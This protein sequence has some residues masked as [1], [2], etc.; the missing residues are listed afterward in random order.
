[1]P[2]PTSVSSNTPPPAIVRRVEAQSPYSLTRDDIQSMYMTQMQAFWT[3][4]VKPTE[5][6]D[7]IPLDFKRQSGISMDIGC[8]SRPRNPT[9]AK[10]LVGVDV[11]Q[12][13]DFPSEADF[14]LTKPGMPLPMGDQSVDI[15]TAF[16]FLEHCWWELQ[17]HEIMEL[18]NHLCAT[19]NLG[20][21]DALEAIVTRRNE[22]RST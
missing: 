11:V 19:P 12:P 8:G 18:S 15:V 21:L 20:N 2:N 22:L 13:K 3:S 7:Y 17:D 10:T 1:M 14:F 5:W 6:I 16:D 4:L 9:R